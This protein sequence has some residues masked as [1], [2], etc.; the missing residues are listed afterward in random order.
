MT[1]ETNIGRGQVLGALEERL[2]SPGLGVD[3]PHKKERALPPKGGT[4]AS[5][6]SLFLSHRRNDEPGT[7]N[8]RGKSR[9]RSPNEGRERQASQRTRS[10]VTVETPARR[11]SQTGLTR[12]SAGAP[13]KGFAQGPVSVEQRRPGSP[14]RA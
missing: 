5:K 1:L 2:L 4:S 7:N 11:G 9:N 3:A 10:G 6:R 8:I 13:D 14:F 12:V